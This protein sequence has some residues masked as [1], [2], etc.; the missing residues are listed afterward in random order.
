LAAPALNAIAAWYSALALGLI[1]SIFDANAES[2][3]LLAFGV[4]TFVATLRLVGTWL[5]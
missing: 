3:T 2:A 4:V 1:A 5:E